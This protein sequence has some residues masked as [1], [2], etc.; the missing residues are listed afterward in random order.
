MRKNFVKIK[1][2]V[3][4]AEIARRLKIDKSYVGLLFAGKRKSK[5]RLEQIRKILLKELSI[6]EYDSA[7][8]KKGS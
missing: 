4:Q 2:M 3:N 1:P 5:K 6:L 7:N 8:M